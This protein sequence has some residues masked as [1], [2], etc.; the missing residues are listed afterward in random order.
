M[1]YRW[2]EGGKQE[3]MKEGYVGGEGE[4]K[5]EGEGE[6]RICGGGRE[7]HTK[8]L[9]MLQVSNSHKKIIIYQKTHPTYMQILK[10]QNTKHWS[11][12]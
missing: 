5:R 4:R 9:A 10:Q 1:I 11:I 12:H 7:R 3:R 6:G 8:S 2:G